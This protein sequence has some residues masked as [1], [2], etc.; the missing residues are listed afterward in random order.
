[1]GADSLLT[2]HMGTFMWAIYHWYMQM[3][4][5]LFLDLGHIHITYPLKNRLQPTFLL[6]ESNIYC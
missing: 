4:G 2:F 6:S 3:Q 5:L 1:M